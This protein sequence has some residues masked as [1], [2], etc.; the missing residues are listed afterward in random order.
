MGGISIDRGERGRIPH[1]PLSALRQ[2]KTRLSFGA[3]WID[4]HSSGYVVV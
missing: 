2:L 4:D 1:S 3:S